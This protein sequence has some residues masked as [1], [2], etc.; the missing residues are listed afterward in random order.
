MIDIAVVVIALILIVIIAA[1]I[2]HA[3]N[4]HSTRYFVV[5]LIRKSMHFLSGN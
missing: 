1:L 3:N 5:R 2:I 4:K